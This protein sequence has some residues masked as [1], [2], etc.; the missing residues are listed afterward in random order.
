[1]DRGSGLSLEGAFLATSLVLSHLVVMSLG[2][3]ALL[4]L[5]ARS[6]AGHWAQIGELDLLP[7]KR[8]P[9]LVGEMDIKSIWFYS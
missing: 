9:H 8:D 6:C 1:M 4:H 5:C 2:H 7:P 3:L